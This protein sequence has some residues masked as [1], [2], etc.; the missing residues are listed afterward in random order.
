MTLQ[1]ALAFAGVMLIASVPIAVQLVTTK[2]LAAGSRS[3][4]QHGAIV[5]R[6]AAVEEL[7]GAFRLK[8]SCYRANGPYSSK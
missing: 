4:S 6:L 2:T 7:A 3:L 8:K 5:T 1:D